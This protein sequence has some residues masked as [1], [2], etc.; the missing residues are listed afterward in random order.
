MKN[1][2]AP[3]QKQTLLPTCIAMCN[4]PDDAQKDFQTM[5]TSSISKSPTFAQ[6]QHCLEWNCICGSCAQNH[7][8]C[9]GRQQTLHNNWS[10]PKTMP[11][12]FWQLGQGILTEPQMYK[13]YIYKQWK[14]WEILGKNRC[15]FAC[16]GID[17]NPNSTP[18]DFACE[19]RIGLGLP[20]LSKIRPV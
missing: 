13:L 10:P 7:T 15:S 17:S 6:H 14:Y 2:G 11:R 20:P 16:V 4:G 1:D 12:T 19:S 18:S 5:P 8:K 9:Q 3:C